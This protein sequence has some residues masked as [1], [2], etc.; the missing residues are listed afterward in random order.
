MSE[1]WPLIKGKYET[2]RETMQRARVK[3]GRKGVVTVIK[4]VSQMVR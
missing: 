2:P 3:D 4:E 1:E